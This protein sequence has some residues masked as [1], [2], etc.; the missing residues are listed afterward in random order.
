MFGFIWCDLMNSDIN[1]ICWYQFQNS[2]VM[3]LW[4]L[5]RF[6]VDVWDILKFVGLQ[7]HEV[8]DPQNPYPRNNNDLI[9]WNHFYSWGTNFCGFREVGWSTKLRNQR[10][11]KLG[12]EFDIDILANVVLE[13]PQLSGPAALGTIDNF[14][15]EINTSIPFNGL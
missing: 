13:W 4:I 3:I 10:T 6:H 5:R 1:I 7:I 12:M 2:R 11:M 8:N 9:L 15:D 14:N